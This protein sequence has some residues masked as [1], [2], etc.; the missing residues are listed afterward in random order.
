MEC[1]L[2]SISTYVSSSLLQTFIDAYHHHLIPGGSVQPEVYKLLH[3]PSSRHEQTKRGA[4]V[5]TRARQSLQ[6]VTFLDNVFPSRSFGNR[7]IH[8]N[9]Y[10]VGI[11][12]VYSLI[13]PFTR[14][15]P[16][17]SSIKIQRHEMNEQV[18]TNGGMYTCVNLHLRLFLIVPDI[19]RCLPSPSDLRPVAPT[20]S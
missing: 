12:E 7:R 13:F 11:E 20:R 9:Q 8:L 18:N 4:V 6:S 16:S 10:P 17:S 19:R 14:P 2:V 1:T 15:S 3:T 5:S